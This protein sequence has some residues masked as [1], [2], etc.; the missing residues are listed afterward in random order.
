MQAR[1]SRRCAPIGGFQGPRRKI[2][3]LSRN[4]NSAIAEPVAEAVGQIV[5]LEKNACVFLYPVIKTEVRDH[6][7][8]RTTGTPLSFHFQSQLSGSP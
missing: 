6:R 5:A 4:P 2:S 3:A 8:S 1:L 7:I